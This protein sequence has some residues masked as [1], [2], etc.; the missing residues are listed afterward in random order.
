MPPSP[1][2]SRIDAKIIGSF[3][4]NSAIEPPSSGTEKRFLSV[5]T[6]HSGAQIAQVYLSSAAEVDA[7]VKNA[8]TAFQSWSALTTKSRTG[9]LRKYMA[10]VENKYTDELADLIVREHGKTKPEALAEIQKGNETLDYA[11]SMPQLAQGRILQVSRGV[12]CYDERC[13]LGVVVSIVPLYTDSFKLDF[14]NVFL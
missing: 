1:K 9:Y 13:P 2:R 6:P 10:L 4:N 8:S 3:S 5:T 12:T 14:S 11:C 7:V